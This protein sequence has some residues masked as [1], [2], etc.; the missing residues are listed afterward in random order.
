MIDL[1]WLLLILA[2]VVVA[3][4]QGQ[5]ERVT[6]AAM[7][8][9]QLAL[10]SLLGLAGIMI[11][12]LG[13]ARIAQEAGM[14]QALA[15]AMAPA[16]RFLFPGLRRDHPAMGAILMNISANMLGLGHAATPFG[17]KAMQELQHDNPHPE[18]ATDAM[19]TFLALNTSSVT[20]VPATVIAIRAAAGATSPTEIVVPSL[21][22]TMASTI[23]ALTVDYL[24]RRLRRGD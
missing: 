17:L 18:R 9:A 8:S 10:E 5:I 2:G 19:V 3:A 22:A 4:L 7:T 13:L 21:L 20:L 15:R 16:F 23:T 11:F 12:W 14:I 24:L 6:E 1:V